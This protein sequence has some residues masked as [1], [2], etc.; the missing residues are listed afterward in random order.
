MPV[1]AS[2]LAPNRIIKTN[3]PIPQDST[4]SYRSATRC[5]IKGRSESC[6]GRPGFPR[7]RRNLALAQLAGSEVEASA[8]LRQVTREV[9]AQQGALAAAEAALKQQRREDAEAERR[10]IRCRADSAAAQVRAASELA[11]H[12]IY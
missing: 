6:A 9:A 3:N 12:Y 5:A 8:Q 10:L 7:R 4:R 11:P 1:V 2:Q